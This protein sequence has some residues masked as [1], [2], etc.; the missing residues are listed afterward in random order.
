METKI[1][2]LFGGPNGSMQ[3]IDVPHN[4]SKNSLPIGT[5][6]HLNGY[7]DPDFVVVENEGINDRFPSY[8]T[9]YL[10]VNI[11]TKTFQKHD[12]VS[13]RWESEK[14]DNRIQTYI[15]DR[16]LSPD[17]VLELYEEARRNQQR[18]QEAKER[19]NEERERLL[20]EG[21][22]LFEK[23]IPENARALI[24][25][26]HDEDRSDLMT[27]YFG[28]VTLETV[29]I[30][31]S[32][33]TRDI[34]SEMRAHASRIPETAHLAEKNPEFEH[35]EKYSMG[36][37]YYLKDGYCHHT[38]WSISKH[39]K[40]GDK[41]DAD[42]YISL[43]KRCIFADRESEPQKALRMPESTEIHHNEDKN[44]IEISF[45]SKPER[46]T[47]D[48]LKE[49]GFRWSKFQKI[50]YAKYSE[51]LYSECKTFLTGEVE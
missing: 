7:D 46:E 25:A 30:G 44:G 29:I 40:Y 23:H 50:W 10:C 5:V 20:A 47:L 49:R 43:A 42:L 15:T 24:L 12:A 26:R 21:V 37:G 27:D 39:K 14:R 51:P 22:R 36:R 35:R 2:D 17:E 6:L 19:A 3:R 33:H 45:P 4:A 8:G 28:S 1:Y 38:G 31:Y 16:K 13:L 32:T 34:F 41:W 11:R 18:E 48:W 9:R